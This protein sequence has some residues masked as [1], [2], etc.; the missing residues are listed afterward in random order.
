M[1]T[2]RRRQRLSSSCTAPAERSPAISSRAM[3]FLIS[4]GR[5]ISASVSR[6]SSLK[7]KRVSP[8]GRPFR[9][10]ARITPSSVPPVE[11]RSTFTESPPAALS[12]AA[13]ACAVG[14]PPVTMETLRPSVARAKP[15]TNSEP[16][17]RSVPSESQITSMSGLAASSREMV[18]SASVRSTACGSGLSCLI[19]TR[20]A[21]GGCIEISRLAS[22]SGITATPRLSASARATMSSAVRSRASQLAA[23]PKPSSISSAIGVAPVVVATGGFH[24]GPA[25]ARMTSVA[26]VSRS[27]VSHHGVRAGVSSFGLMSNNSRVGGNSIRRGRGGMSRRIHHNTGRLSRPSSTSGEAK[28]SGRPIMRTSRAPCRA[29]GGWSWPRRCPRRSGHAAPSGDRSPRDRCGGW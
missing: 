23:A 7:A 14:S 6:S 16:R 25:A 10:S 24:K 20:A 21:A 22:P 18:G 17:P 8:S 27:N 28:P 4:T 5:L 12:A 9:S 11:A 15:V 3:S 13:S 26:S 1:P 2:V 29:A 19:R